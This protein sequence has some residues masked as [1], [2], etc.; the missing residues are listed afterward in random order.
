MSMIPLLELGIEIQWV[1]IVCV[2]IRRSSTTMQICKQVQFVTFIIK[3]EVSGVVFSML[4]CA[5]HALKKQFA[6]INL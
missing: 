3:R 1:N 5:V 4:F 6:K 2:C